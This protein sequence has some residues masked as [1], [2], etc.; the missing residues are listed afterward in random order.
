[1]RCIF[2]GFTVLLSIGI[3]HAQISTSTLTGALTDGTGSV[4][5]RALVTA[6]AKSTSF[7][8]TATSNES[9]TYD[10]TELPP[11]A[12]G[13]SAEAPGFKKAVVSEIQLFVGQTAT[14]DIQLELGQVTESVSVTSEAPLLQEESGQVGTVI[15]GKQLTDIPLN[16][17]NF[18]QLNLLSP[19]VTR[20]KNSNTFDAVTI[21]PTAQ[22]FNVNGQHGDYNLYLLDGA[23]IKEYQHGT[24]T[25]SPSVDAVQEFQTTTSNYSAAFGAE[26][27]AQVNLVTRSG[28]NSYHGG[29]YEFLRNNKLDANNF[30]SQTVGAP[31]FERNQFGGTLGGPIQI[32]KIYNGKNRTFFFVSTESF[33]ERKNIPQQGNYPT[34]AQ[35]A[36]DLSTLVPPGQGADRSSERR[37]L[38]QQPHSTVSRM[39]STLLPFIQTG[40]RQRS[41]D[42]RA[43]F[44]RAGIRLFS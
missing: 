1:M 39:P 24:N 27:G 6:T 35:F 9:G 34:P 42:S 26:A 17:R 32:P 13:I 8:R 22:S 31:P 11:G 16:G 40:I 29:V 7:S 18:L 10:I 43:Q 5:P 33:R 4:V 23:T 3:S 19:G 15:E 20:S 12:Y 21:N 44:I 41:V 36:G 25:F 2:V 28:T 38:S 30:F 14:V 37:P